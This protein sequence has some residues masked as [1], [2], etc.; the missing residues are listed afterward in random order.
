VNDLDNFVHSKS[1]PR[2][3]IKDM[4]AN[5]KY[6]VEELDPSSQS[7][8]I[9]H[10]NSLILVSMLYFSLRAYSGIPVDHFETSSRFLF[11]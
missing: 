11:S 2:F 7:S 6:V 10:F 5:P 1:K 9:V 8:Y 3:I 4:D